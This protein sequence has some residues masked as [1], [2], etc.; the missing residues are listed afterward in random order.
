MSRR[1]NCSYDTVAQIIRDADCKIVGRTRL[2]KIAFLLERAGLGSGLS[3]EYKHYGPYSEELAFL[4]EKAC[5]VGLVDEEEKQA[6]WGGFYSVFSVDNSLSCSNSKERITL[7]KEAAEADSIALELAATAVFLSEDYSNSWAEVALR[8]PE[9][10]S[11]ERL[12][13][14]KDLL[15]RLSA[16]KSPKPLPNLV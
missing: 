14:A 3:F 12:S 1:I 13:K 10:A 7:I 2:Q 4:C 15:S 8:K 6:Q 5:V 9:K 16:I 11:S